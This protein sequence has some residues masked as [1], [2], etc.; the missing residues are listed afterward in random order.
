MRKEA[1][2]SIRRGRMSQP[3][4]LLHFSEAADSEINIFLRKSGGHLRADAILPLRD[5]RI[6]ESYDVYALLQHAAG[7][8]LRRLRIVQHDRDY[9]VLSGKKIEAQLLHPAA[10][11][12]GILVNTVTKLGGFFQQLN[13]TDRG[14]ADSI[15]TN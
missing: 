11:V 12:A 4:L 6:A 2:A 5:N 15:L 7:E 1:P 3:H 13:R 10:E 14:R 9:G 8:F